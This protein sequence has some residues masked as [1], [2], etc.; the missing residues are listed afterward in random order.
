ML[1]VFCLVS[2]DLTFPSSSYSI[3]SLVPPPKTPSSSCSSVIWC[4]AYLQPGSSLFRLP[5]HHHIVP[6]YVDWWVRQDQLKFSFSLYSLW[7][8]VQSLNYNLWKEVVFIFSIL[9]FKAITSA[10]A[11][12]SLSSVLWYLSF[13]CVKSD[14]SWVLIYSKV[15][16]CYLKCSIATSLFFTV[17]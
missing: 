13:D 3:P 15:V 2:L 4:F 12:L 6:P 14:N 7:H 10:T 8:L 1:S 11:R 5:Q 16:I 9:P 17:S